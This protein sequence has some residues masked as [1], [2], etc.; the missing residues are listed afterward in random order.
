MKLS[1]NSFRFIMAL[2]I[3]VAIT[4]CTGKQ[5]QNKH[6]GVEYYR[7]LQFSET[8][9]DIEKGTHRI[10]DEEAQKVNSYKFT[11]DDKGT[12]LSVEYV[13][14]NNLLEYSSMGVPK[15]AFEY[16]GNMQTKYFYNKAGE[17]VERNGV[18]ALE[19]ARNND[20]DR[21]EMMFY[22]KAGQMVNNSN[23]IHH[24]VWQKL[25]DG[26][27]RENRYNLEGEEVVM[28]PFCPFYELRFT[29]NDK[30][31]VTRMAN[32]M[33]D[34]LYN[35]TAENCGDIGVSYFTFTPNENGDVEAFEVFN[36]T[37]QM[38]NLYWGWSKRL[39]KFDENG[40][41]IET[42]YYDQD[43]EMVS[44]KLVP[45]TKYSYDEHGA[46][47]EISSYDKNGNLINDPANGVAI[48]KYSYDEAG[49][50]TATARFDVNNV[51][52]IM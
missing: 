47:I 27:I 33:A 23:N 40:N 50:R 52:V 3:I 46:V 31:F 18:F 7:Q 9:Y 21:V 19:Y 36:V 11:Y 24:Y 13:R 48:T 16:N 2:M 45:V 35:C 28:N 30:G 26:M 12:L 29:Y 22:N 41:V 1:V 34:T 32:Y 10:S 6:S 14:N 20:G 49:N 44:G 8:P 5:K 37:G 42:A 43:N 15:I 51:A 39:S 25:P 4:S 38:S 17:K